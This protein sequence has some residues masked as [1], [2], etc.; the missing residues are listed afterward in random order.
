M[1][2]APH[3]LP[4]CDALRRD[5]RLRDAYA[6][7]KRRLAMAHCPDRDAYTAAKGPFAT[8]VLGG[9]VTA[10]PTFT[11]DQAGNYTATPHAVCTGRRRR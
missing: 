6:D 9:A 10:S 2:I 5:L 1:P 3:G 7:L 4:R 11:P 8:Q